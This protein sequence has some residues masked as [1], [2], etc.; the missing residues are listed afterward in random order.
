LCQSATHRDARHGWAGRKRLDRDRGGRQGG[1]A[2]VCRRHGCRWSVNRAPRA[3]DSRTHCA[4]ALL[5]SLKSACAPLPTSSTRMQQSGQG[6]RHM[7]RTNAQPHIHVHSGRQHIA[8]THART[9]AYTH[10][11][12]LKQSTHRHLLFAPSASRVET[13][14]ARNWAATATLLQM[15]FPPFCPPVHMCCESL[16]AR[17][18]AFCNS[19]HA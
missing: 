6:R 10:T 1:R 12:I 9:C 7:T 17:G 13:L 18:P 3:C 5:T 16:E 14:A 19:A 2:R 15:Y 4:A 11:C 8:R